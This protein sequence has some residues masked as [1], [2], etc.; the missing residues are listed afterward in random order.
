MDVKLVK[1]IPNLIQAI[2]LRIIVEKGTAILYKKFGLNRIVSLGF[3]LS[4]LEN[5]KYR[6]R[7]TILSDTRIDGIENLELS[8]ENDVLVCDLT[9]SV[10]GFNDAVPLRLT[11]G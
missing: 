7:E 1:G 8:Q 10:K 4:D 3:T 11:I 6:I 2:I 5:A 9:I